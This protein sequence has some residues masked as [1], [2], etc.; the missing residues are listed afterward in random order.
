MDHLASIG[1][2]VRVAEARSFAAAAAR[3]DLSPTMVA[4]HVRALEARLGA[5]LIER[6]TR[7]QALTEVGTAYLER[8]REVLASVEAAD[9]VAEALRHQPRGPLRVT[10]PVTYGAHR[11]VPAIAAYNQAFPEVQVELHLNDRVVDLVEEGFHVGV[12]SG[13]TPGEGLVTLPLK[14]SAMVASAS[15]AY[16]ARRGMALHPGDLAGHDCLAFTVWGPGH[17]WRFT[18]GT[19]TATVPINGPFIANNGQALLQAALAG[20]GVIVQADVVLDQ[21]I[22]AGLLTRLL[23]DWSLPT[24]PVQLVHVRRG[25]PSAKVRSFV[26]FIAGRL[27]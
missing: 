9:G 8:C 14:P 18:R 5:R 21:P 1:V 12:R 20:M 16:L 27:G 2:F 23:P 25:P 26:D 4:N 19:E 3:L 22:A 15:P 17:A 6:T 7:R 24:R 13:R 11:L 10:A